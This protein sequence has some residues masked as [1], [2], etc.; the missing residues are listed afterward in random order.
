MLF[1]TIFAL[2]NKLQTEGDAL[3]REITAKQWFLIACIGVIA[4]EKP[5]LSNLERV[6]GSSRQNIKQLAIKLEQK[7]FLTIHRDPEDARNLLLEVTDFAEKFFA[8]RESEMDGFIENLFAG[9]PKKNVDISL[10]T[11]RQMEKSV[12]D[13][14]KEY[15]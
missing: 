8:A 3:F 4:P 10:K 11:L 12:G 13:L 14:R 5:T 15:V 7:G 1:G 9:I 2:A 6:M